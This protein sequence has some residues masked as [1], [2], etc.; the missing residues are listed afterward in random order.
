MSDIEQITQL[1]LRERQ[2]RDR[3]WWGQ[4]ADTYSPAARVRVSWLEA[5]ASEFVEHSKRIVFPGIP[6]AHKVGTPVIHLNGSRAL[7]EA[8]CTIQ[9]R[10]EI[11][12]AVVNLCSRIRL[13][14]RV[15]RQGG[16]WLIDALDAL[17][18]SDELTPAVLGEWPALDMDVL[19]TRRESY[20]YL[21]Y[22]QWLRTGQ[23]IPDDLPGDDR[24][25]LLE[26]LYEEAFAWLGSPI[27]KG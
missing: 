8:P 24:R 21:A 6:L 14:Y 12:G 10:N 15:E 2:G 19:L 22:L 3:G 26:T 20:R 27:L 1:V 9:A 5:S 25:E 17:Y 11:Q 16:R 23:H 13:F 7:V 18:E 4:M